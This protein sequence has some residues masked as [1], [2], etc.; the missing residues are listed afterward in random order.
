[1]VRAALASGVALDPVCGVP[2]VVWAAAAR[3]EGLRALEE[4]LIR[5]G[6]KLDPKA[7]S[8]M[9]QD[10]ARGRRTEVALINGAA[11]REAARHG[12]P[13]PMN[14]ALIARLDGPNPG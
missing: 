1:M 9:V 11:A 6:E 8:G 5:Y 7:V 2:G 12:L 10:R 4:A 14:A 3:G 13:A